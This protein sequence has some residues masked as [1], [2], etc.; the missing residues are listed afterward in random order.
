MRTLLALFPLLLVPG[1]MVAVI[2]RFTSLR[3]FAR[4]TPHVRW[5][6]AF[7]AGLYSWVFIFPAL[8][9]LASA[10]NYAIAEF[11]FE[12][13]LGTIA[14]VTRANILQYKAAVITEL[15][16]QYL[17]PEVFRSGCITRQEIV[18]RLAGVINEMSGISGYM[19]LIVLAALFSAVIGMIMVLYI[20]RPPRAVAAQ[21]G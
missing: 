11:Y 1:L 7:I 13:T 5:A 20:T 10:L 16:L 15:W 21:A 18:C 8:V 14:G 17:T 12:T 9:G 3:A 4:K 6:M 2:V 19:S